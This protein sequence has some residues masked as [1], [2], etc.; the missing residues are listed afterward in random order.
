VVTGS[1]PGPIGQSPAT[2]SSS[3]SLYQI[4]T[5]KWGDYNSPLCNLKLFFLIRRRERMP[6]RIWL[7][8]P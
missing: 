2:T 6:L 8:F 7:A 1:Y 5:E 3:S 4:R